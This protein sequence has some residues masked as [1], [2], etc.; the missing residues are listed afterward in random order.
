MNNLVNMKHLLL[1]I[2]IYVLCLSE[3][4]AQ[5]L[6]TER[7]FLASKKENSLPGD[8]LQI[9][10]QLVAADS[11]FFPLSRY[12]YLEC[13]DAQDSLLVRQK[14]VCDST[15]YF[16]T[17]L[18]TQFEWP[19]GIYYLRGYT[20]LMQNFAVESYPV[21]PLLI[22]IQSPQRT[23]AY[24]LKLQ[25]FPE[26]GKRVDGFMQNIIAYVT[27]MNGYPIETQGIALL[28]S[29]NDTVVRQLN[30]SPVGLVKCTFMPQ[31]GET[32]R[33]IVPH[34]GKEFLLPIEAEQGEVTLQALINRGKLICSIFSADANPDWHLYIY[35][36]DKGVLEM[37][38]NAERKM[39][40]MS[41]AG[42]SSG[43]LALFLT[44]A[45]QNVL[46]QRM[47]WIPDTVTNANVRCQLEQ[48]ILRPGD[49]LHY[50]IKGVENGKI[51]ERIVSADNLLAMQA[52][53]I[54]HFGSDLHSPIPFPQLENDEW[55][56]TAGQLDNWLC[57][58]R[59]MRFPLKQYLQDKMTFSYY[60][61]DIMLISGKAIDRKGKPFDNGLIDVQNKRA[62]IFYT[63][64]IDKD[65]EFTIPVNDFPTGTPFRL[66]AKNSKGKIEECGFEIEELP[67]PGVFI[68]RHLFLTENKT[69]ES[70]IL[71]GDTSFQYSIDENNQ[72][73]YSINKIIVESRR[74]INIQEISR[75]PTNY[76][77]T[78]ELQKYG[79]MSIRSMLIRFPS[80]QI[81]QNGTGSG[82]GGLSGTL[83]DLKQEREA[84]QSNRVTDAFYN[85]REYG[86]TTI[87][88]K[89]IR[90]EGFHKLG[91]GSA[92]R[93]NVVVDGEVQM[94]NIDHIL[95]WSAG[96]IRSIEVIK[97]TDTRCA[98]YNTPSGAIL[99][100][101]LYGTPESKEEEKGHTI[102]PLGLSNIGNKQPPH[103]LKA[104]MKSGKYTLLI[105]VITSDKQIHSFSKHI[106]VKE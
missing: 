2:S 79:A 94:G 51:I 81:T 102:Y 88:W 76:I 60:I 59:F 3:S 22:G 55:Q 105:D 37:P 97:P 58:T 104:P 96:D 80:I 48:E 90:Y 23:E 30:T 10:G 100:E 19:A 63:G 92:R 28:N 53:E 62:Q 5:S 67:Y 83:K 68:P 57:T 93:L 72:K 78:E 65:G 56:Q 87:E 82:G 103:Q 24:S 43:L 36:A 35:H 8:T 15:G 12:L 64:V 38:L 45:E 101:T 95:D 40:V 4:H 85:G 6:Y 33:M 42:Y 106:E 34:N 70:I 31:V 16:C 89:S 71:N 75:M 74:P 69:N 49:T 18:P 29:Q 27:D 44:D 7:L 99:I 98:I 52:A 13:I 14:V 50:H 26:G 21:V 86:E 1:L 66:T 46:S 17:Y 73:V 77:G 25:A 32:Y 84:R 20:R 54:L 9:E 61:E 11:S 39:A 41:L 91:E 47:L